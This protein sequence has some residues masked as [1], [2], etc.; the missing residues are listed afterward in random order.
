VSACL[1]SFVSCQVHVED[2]VRAL[3]LAYAEIQEQ[4]AALT[5]NGSEDGAANANAQPSGADTTAAAN[6]PHTAS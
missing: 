4:L 1:V 5:P 6:P 2:L 3:K